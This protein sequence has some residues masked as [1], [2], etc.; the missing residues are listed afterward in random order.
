M[1]DEHLVNI[2]DMKTS[3]PTMDYSDMDSLSLYYFSPTDTADVYQPVLISRKVSGIQNATKCP[4]TAFIMPSE[5][6][7]EGN[8]GVGGINSN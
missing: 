6:I 8:E 1:N 7:C 2:L 5:T 4:P 3:V